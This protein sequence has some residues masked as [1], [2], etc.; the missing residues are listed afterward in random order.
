MQFEDLLD[1]VINHIF[2]ISGVIYPFY[3][4][5]TRLYRITQQT[6]RTIFSHLRIDEFDIIPNDLSF[7]TSLKLERLINFNN[8]PNL[9][10]LQISGSDHIDKLTRLTK[11]VIREYESASM[12]KDLTNLTYLNIFDHSFTSKWINRLT[13]LTYLDVRGINKIKDKHIKRL[14][15]L[16][17][18]EI[19]TKLSTDT[20]ISLTNLTH[21]YLFDI[22]IDNNT[23]RLLTNLKSLVIMTEGVNIDY[24]IETLTNLITFKPNSILVNDETLTKL[25]NITELSLCMNYTIHSTTLYKL[26][27]LI[28]LNLNLNSVCRH[29]NNLTNLTRLNIQSASCKYDLIKLTNLTDLSVPT[30]FRI[31]M[32]TLTNLIKLNLEDCQIRYNI[33][34]LIK[35]KNLNIRH[36]KW[37]P[38]IL[39]LTNLTKLKT[40]TKRYKNNSGRL[41]LVEL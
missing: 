23:L 19:S 2:C 40:N 34:H 30:H 14:T 7:V 27:H 24:G 20:L 13:N 4:V 5:S 41:H 32:I 12:I 8:I 6:K 16:Q 38:D 10:S 36:C 11:L 35:L 31:N 39:N 25:T 21:L 22:I 9:T 17:S 33:S 26:P 18:L 1:E 15:N 29:I 37:N 3:L 28:D